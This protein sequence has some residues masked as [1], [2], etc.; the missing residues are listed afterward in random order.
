MIAVDLAPGRLGRVL[1][2][3]EVGYHPESTA[4]P[5][6]GRWLATAC[7]GAGKNRTP[8]SVIRL[9]ASPSADRPTFATTSFNLADLGRRFG[10]PDDDVEPEYVAFAP[11][12][13]FLVASCQENDGVLLIDLAGPAPLSPRSCAPCPAPGRTG[14]RCAT[15]IATADEGDESKT[16]GQSVSFFTFDPAAPATPAVRVATVDMRPIATP[17]KPERNC[18]PENIKLVRLAGRLL[19]LVVMEDRNG[20]AVLDAT[21]PGKPIPAGILT[22]GTRPEGIAVVEEPDRVRV[23]TGDEGK[24]DFGGP[25]EITIGEIRPAG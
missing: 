24:K 6:D 11:D 25:G 12:S 2:T 17:S 3:W 16:K 19:A 15:V 4:I 10:V 7:E 23:I 22:T 18:D 21:A 8:G 1:Q 20:V 14:W 5:P 13:R 9:D